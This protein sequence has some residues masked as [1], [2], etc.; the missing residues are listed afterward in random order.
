METLRKPYRVDIAGVFEIPFQT[1]E[2]ANEFAYGFNLAHRQGFSV[3]S[4]GFGNLID[5]ERAKDGMQ[6]RG[7]VFA[8]RFHA[9]C[10]RYG[11]ELKRHMARVSYEEFG[12]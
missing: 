7:M 12:C 5:N 9:W 3:L 1:K 2:S 8:G 4:S 10:L 11:I 6:Y